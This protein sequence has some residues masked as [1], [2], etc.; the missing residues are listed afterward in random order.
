LTEDIPKS[1]RFVP[2]D[3]RWNI[4]WFGR[5]AASDARDPESERAFP[6]AGSALLTPEIEFE[7]FIAEAGWG[8]FE[9]IPP[10]VYEEDK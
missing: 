8:M 6:T 4:G 7:R 10:S 2:D 5:G 3:V 1:A 9:L